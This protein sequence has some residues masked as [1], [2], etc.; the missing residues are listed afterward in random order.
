MSASYNTC[1]NVEETP[2]VDTMPSP[3]MATMDMP[4]SRD[5]E[6]IVD[7][8]VEIGAFSCWKQK[9]EGRILRAHTHTTSS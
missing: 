5:T 2:E 7:L 9:R 6:L 8:F 4:L 1:M 3:T